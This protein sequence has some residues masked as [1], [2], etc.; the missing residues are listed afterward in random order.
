MSSTK[1]CFSSAEGLKTRD[2]QVLRD[3]LALFPRH[4]AS[5]GLVLPENATAENL[6]YGKIREV[7]MTGD[8]PEDLDD[9]LHL[10]S[11]LNTAKGWS[12]IERQAKEDGRR[13]PAD[14]PQYGYVDLAILAAIQDWPTNKT[15]L[16]RANARARVHSRSAYVYHAPSVDLRSHYRTPSATSLAKA[17]EFLVGHFVAEGMVS[18]RQHRKATEIV[19]Y[20]FEK[21]IWF[22]IRYPGRQSRHSGCDDNGEW[23]NFVFNPEQYDAV[24]YNKVYCD[25]RMNTKRKREHAKYRIA[26]S[27]LLFDLANAFR[28]TGV[29][30]TL[31]P[32]LRNDA[33]NL[34]EC[35]DIPGLGMIL[36]VTMTFE[37]FGLPPRE[38]TEAALDGSSL[39]QGNPHAQRLLPRDAHCVRSVVLQ[40]RLKNSTRLSRLTID[41]ANKVSFERD[42]DS[43]VVEEWL[44]RRGFVKN[45]VEVTDHVPIRVAHD[46]PAAAS[47]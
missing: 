17:R 10:S 28:P 35:D 42:G 9:I 2:P 23:R 46:L 41:E 13:L 5:R 1:R 33:V 15:I 8:I 32:L 21:E 45:F 43:V 31:E 6:D 36:P 29:V 27:H 34:F 47:A 16:E 4:I 3:L 14:L 19:P 20:D 12:M 38:W 18:D 30:V 25:L 26:F 7:L 11:L 22:L 39:L 44:R 37:T 40:Y 24:A